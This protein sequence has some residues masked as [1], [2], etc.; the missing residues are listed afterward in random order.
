M[1]QPWAALV[2][3]MAQRETG[4]AQA[5]GAPP[6]TMTAAVLAAARA[7]NPG[8]NIDMLQRALQAPQRSPPKKQAAMRGPGASPTE[9]DDK[10]VKFPPGRG[11]SS[12][13]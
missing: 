2:A 8:L 12:P 9:E 5:A 10:Q 11:A 1:D 13:L 4:A 7:M 6:G 3:Q